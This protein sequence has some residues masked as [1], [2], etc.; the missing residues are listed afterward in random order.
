MKLDKHKEEYFKPTVL[1]VYFIKEI[2]VFLKIILF[3]L[4]ISIMYIFLFAEPIFLS[5]SKIMSSSTKNSNASQFQGLVSQ[6]GVSLPNLSSEK[7]WAY[8]EI[9]KSR[10]FAKKIIQSSFHDDKKGKRK[11]LDI[12]IERDVLPDSSRINLGIQLY[13]D[14][15]DIQE[16]IKTGVF[17]ITT[18]SNEGA[19]SA[20]VNKKIIEELD[21][22]QKRF[23]KQKTSKARKFIEERIIDTY[24]ELE[25]A[26]N[27]LKDFL[28]RNRRI[29]NSPSLQLA[30]ERLTREVTVI[31]GVYT[32]LKQQLEST[33]IE[34]V[35]DSDY[36]I[37]IDPPNYPE[38]PF[39]P[40]KLF[41]LV[42]A[43]F[44]GFGTSFLWLLIKFYYHNLSVSENGRHS[45]L[46]NRIFH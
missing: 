18:R 3:S 29:D 4:V 12:F 35:K 26:E 20:K 24:S 40:N 11:L 37:V 42:T 41:L 38:H 34:E 27:K 36:I 9:I 33:K 5:K 16:N 6:F 30:Q 31:N 21:L 43:I 17:T 45:N 23:N 39:S 28:D 1:I 44:I 7:K 15:V 25:L 32:T 46:I 13:M 22:H 2:Q 10:I 14:M 19:L 8:S